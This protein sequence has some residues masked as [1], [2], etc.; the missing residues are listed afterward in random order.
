MDNSVA[1]TVEPQ[2]EFTDSLMQDVRVWIGEFGQF[3]QTG[4][5]LEGSMYKTAMESVVFEPS[6]RFLLTMP[7]CL[8]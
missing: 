3:N 8:P 4:L 6:L 2:A 5:Q 1:I 7:C